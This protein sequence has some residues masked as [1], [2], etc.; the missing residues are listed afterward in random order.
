MQLKNIS[1][2][3]IVRV[4]NIEL[5]NL[6]EQQVKNTSMKTTSPMTTHSVVQECSANE[7]SDGPTNRMDSIILN[8]IEIKKIKSRY[9]V[10]AI[11]ST[12]LTKKF[13]D[14]SVCVG[15]EVL[16]RYHV[17]LLFLIFIF[18]VI[19][20]NGIYCEHFGNV[21]KYIQTTVIKNMQIKNSNTG[22]IY[23]V[24]NDGVSTLTTRQ[25][26]CTSLK[27]NQSSLS[28]QQTVARAS[29]QIASK[30]NSLLLNGISISKKDSKY[31]VSEVNQEILSRKFRNNSIQVGDEV[32]NVLFMIS[33]NT[34]LILRF[35]GS[36]DQ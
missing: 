9:Y 21:S 24:D 4:E 20:I 8:G 11:N 10:T 33:I 26:D 16:Y 29:V 6:L 31:Y 5:L 25:E 14:N 1:T 36:S 19:Q 30:L 32:N 27:N 17:I 35:L 22:L 18:K 13:P 12:I 28:I 3:D 2:G 23:N 7:N 15:N 34:I